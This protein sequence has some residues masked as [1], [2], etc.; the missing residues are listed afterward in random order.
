M[1]K[2]RINYLK[3][4]LLKLIIP[5]FAIALVTLGDM[6]NRSGFPLNSYKLFDRNH[7]RSTNYFISICKTK[8][9]NDRNY[10]NRYSVKLTRRQRKA[11]YFISKQLGGYYKNGKYN[12]ITAKLARIGDFFNEPLLHFTLE[13]LTYNPT[14]LYTKNIFIK[15]ERLYDYKH[16]RRT[17]I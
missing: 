11:L 4:H 17:D 16:K 5:I 3:N 13:E 12:K 7:H 15:R 6:P 14:M 1:Y 9:P 8:C 2:K 10:I